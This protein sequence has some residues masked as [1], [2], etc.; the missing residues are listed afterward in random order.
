MSQSR[1]N[2]LRRSRLSRILSS[3]YP[4]GEKTSKPGACRGE[5]LVLENLEARQLLAGDVS[6]ADEVAMGPIDIRSELVSYEVSAAQSSSLTTSTIPEGEPA[7]DLVQFAKD[8]EQAG[9]IFYG[10][11]WCPV[12]TNQKELFQ[13]GKDNLPFIEVTNPDRSIAQIGIDNNITAYPTWVFPDDTRETGLLTLQQLSDRSGVSIPQSEMPTFEPIGNQTALIGSP[14]HVPVDAYDPDGGALTVTVS[15]ANPSLL[16][17]N[18][19]TG[20]RSIRIDMETYG[21]MVFEL[22]EQRAPAPTSRIIELAEDGFYDDIIFHRV[23]N[24]FVIQ[25]GDPTGTGSGGSNLGD[26]D[27]EFHPELQH[28]R[29][30]ILSYAKSSDDTN[31]SQFFI[32]EEPTR[33]LDYNHSVFG[34]L[35]EGEDVRDAISEHAVNSS[36]RPTTDIAIN[37]I[38]VFTD[39]ENSLIMLKPTGASIGSTDVTVTVTDGDGNTHSET[40]QVD[41]NNDTANSQPYLNPV[42]VPDRFDPNQDATLQLSSTDIEGDAVSYSATVLST[43]TGATASIDANGLLTVTPA[44]GFTGVVNVRG[45]VEPGPGVTGNGQDDSDNQVYSFNFEASQTLQA[46]TS[47]DLRAS[48]DTGSSNTDNITNA[49]TLAFTIDGVTDGAT[50]R[51][52][53][54][55]TSAVLGEAT[56]SGT[57]VTIETTNIAALGDGVY[58][59]TALQIVNAETSPQTDPISITYDNIDPEPVAGS[60]ITTGSVGRL[61]QTDLISAEEGSITYVLTQAPSGSTINSGSGLIEWTPQTG[62]VGNNTFTV[63]TTDLAGNSRTENFTVVVSGEPTAEVKLVLR[64]TD[65]NEVTNLNVG[66]DFV[67]ELIGV[68]ARDTDRDGVFAT[69]A[70]ILFDSSI[71]QVKSGTSIE[72]VGNYQLS[73][74]GTFASGLIDEIGAASTSVVAPF[75]DES[76]IARVQMETIAAGTVNLRSEAADESSS[77]ILLYGQDDEIPATDVF[78]GNVILTVGVDFT[79]IDDSATIAEDSASTLID[80]LDNDTTTGSDTLQIVSF[81]QPTSGGTVSAQDG[82]LFFTPEPDFNGTVT[83]TYIAGTGSGAQ[84]TASVTVTVTP[85]NDPPQAVADTFD[86]TEGTAN[87]RLDV[88]ANDLIAPDSGETLSVSSVSTTAQGGTVEVS[89]DTLAVNYTPPSGFTGTD[90]FTYTVSDGA[91]SDS[92]TVNVTVNSADDPP[93][94]ND[95]T[96]SVNEDTAEA[97]YDILANDTRDAENQSFAIESLGTPSN[98]GS[99]RFSSDGSTFFY[100][101][102]ADFFG[103]ETVSYTIRDTGGGVATGNITFTVTAVNDLPPVLDKTIQINRGSSQSVVLQLSELPENVDGS[104]ETLSF[105]NLGTPSAGGTIDTDSNGDLVYTPPSD[106]FTGTDT[107]T[108]SVS[109]G[110]GDDSNGTLTIEVQDY[111]ERNVSV[112]FSRNTARSVLASTRLVGTDAFGNSVDQ[113]PQLDSDDMLLFEAL[114]PGEYAVEIPALPFFTGGEQAQRYSIDSQPDDGDTVVEATM[115]RIKPEF[116]SIRD[117]L[118]STPEQS[119]LVVVQPGSSALL[120]EP[121]SGSSQS[122]VDPSIA[123]NEAGTSVTISGTDNADPPASRTASV[124]TTEGNV[125]QSRG[126]VGDLRLYRINVSE[127]VVDYDSGASANSLNSEGTGE[128]ESVAQVSVADGV[129]SQTVQRDS[130]SSGLSAQSTAEGEFV[131][132]S[133]SVTEVSA[134]LLTAQSHQDFELQTSEAQTSEQPLVVSEAPTSVADNSASS[135]RF[136]STAPADQSS[137]GDSEAETAES[138][139]EADSNASSSLSASSVD[140]FFRRIR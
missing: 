59:V 126:R 106:S 38:E 82:D 118:G 46:P 134:P 114:L 137:P 27:D 15:V 85:V 138:Q 61:Y 76:V 37:T 77:E 73:P 127:E 107:V 140:R 66:E 20:N 3:L 97:S 99:V 68:D 72:Y 12:C 119:V 2:R 19:I 35:I 31:D 115:G 10:A 51:L 100:A 58:N 7:P 125:V 139:T 90:S 30:G 60:A 133:T 45:T 120:T 71:V 102:A 36:D 14:L 96:F 22:F 112:R 74:K 123:L 109:D 124:L 87:N 21:D 110:V 34:Q 29:G 70:D 49:G 111:T 56:A 98:G 78:Y 95:D 69:Y 113:S 52:I 44:S 67:L 80:V 41:V 63:Q 64:D 17:A 55:Q 47:I 32:T 53:N 40:F 54:Q 83:F 8:L 28:N 94:A 130:G 86:V 91:L 11:H 103:T 16:E 117:W 129:S 48:S 93:T 79:L 4:R 101:P 84:D 136:R 116:I 1:E 132:N 33:F 62:D 105:T 89:S 50:V 9:V 43:G 39:T 13:D 18:V 81:S 108:Y 92:V 57:S 65:G 122:I 25:G 121:T 135:R 24:D 23:I 128:G 75:V 26:F 104:G 42:T 5:R 88:L 131:A 6:A